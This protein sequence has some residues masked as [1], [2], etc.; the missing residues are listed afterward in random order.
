MRTGN[1]KATAFTIVELLVVIAILAILISLLVPTLAKVRTQARV[2]ATRTAIHVIEGGLGLYYSD[3]KIYP[4]SG[5]SGSVAGGSGAANLV[6]CLTGYG[7][8]FQLVPRGKVYGPYGGTERLNVDAQKRFV[9]SWNRPILYYAFDST[10]TR[11][12]SPTA[13]YYG[14]D[15]NSVTPNPASQTPPVDIDA[16]AQDAG[17]NYLNRRYLL[18]S[19]GP[20][21]KYG[22]TANESR[23]DDVTNLRSE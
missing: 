1:K 5:P 7:D 10:P 21:G 8:G 11:G 22:G 20:D 23:C 16:Y 6:W 12:Q 3:H 19:P 2:S 18:L 9:D 13:K 14:D 15:N 4:L 17:G